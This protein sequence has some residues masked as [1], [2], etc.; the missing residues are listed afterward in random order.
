MITIMQLDTGA[1][2]VV[3]VTRAGAVLTSEHA[4]EHDARIAAYGPDYTGPT[5]P[6]AR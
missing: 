5:N 3:N 4:S 2:C 1:W 6:G